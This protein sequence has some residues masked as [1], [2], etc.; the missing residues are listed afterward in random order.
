MYDKRKMIQIY[1]GNGKGKTT[2]ALGL[3][4]RALGQAKKVF[5]IQ[6]MK[7]G[8]NL[9]EVKV[10]RHF[11]E[12]KILQAGREGW[13]K[14]GAA[15]LKDKEVAQKGLRA[16]FKAIASKKYDLIILDELNVAIDFGLLKVQ[17]VKEIL[18]NKPDSL[19]LIIT[20]RGAHPEL[21]EIADLVS[22]IRELKHYYKKGVIAR[23]G[24]EY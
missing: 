16:A 12:F 5:L 17:Q 20:G 22:E 14:K 1:T 11:S 19:E 23:A 7:K 9:G 15:T 2:A 6:F 10:A 3:A 8:K 24:V 18:K 13:V 4:F 21:I